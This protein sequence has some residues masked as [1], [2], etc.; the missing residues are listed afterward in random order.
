[1]CKRWPVTSFDTSPVSSDLRSQTYNTIKQQLFDII[2][3]RLRGS[4]LCIYY[5]QLPKP[6][7]RQE[8]YVVYDN[9][10]VNTISI[11][12]LNFLAFY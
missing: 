10:Y 6:Y 11:S 8:E 2:I 9:P 7:S 3:Q 1:M 12:S 4:K 5:N